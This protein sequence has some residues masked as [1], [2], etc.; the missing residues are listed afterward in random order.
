M[1]SISVEVSGLNG[2]GT[3]TLQNNGFDELSISTDGTHTFT[4]KIPRGGLYSV[5]ESGDGLVTQGI[6]ILA[7]S[8]GTV[9]QAGVSATL[10][11]EASA[12][13]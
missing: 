13:K 8:S 11:C 12:C 10:D 3:V 4:Y 2:L 6:C 9:A 1:Y 5:T 7:S